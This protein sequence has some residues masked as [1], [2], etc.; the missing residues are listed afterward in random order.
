M[1]RPTVGCPECGKK[2]RKGDEGHHLA[3]ECEKRLVSCRFC[4]IV[5]PGEIAREHEE[6]C[7]AKT[8]VCKSCGSYVVVRD[9]VYHKKSCEED[10]LALPCEFCERVVPANELA[11]HQRKCL[12]HE[13][14][15]ENYI[16]K[17]D[18]A[19]TFRPSATKTEE[20]ESW[21]NNFIKR[22]MEKMKE[23]KEGNEA[24]ARK[25]RTGKKCPKSHRES[26]SI[27]A[28][29][30]EI[31]GELCPSD[32]LMD[33][34]IECQQERENAR[35][36]NPKTAQH[37]SSGERECHF[38]K[39]DFP[40]KADVRYI[41]VQMGYSPTIE[42]T[43]DDESFEGD[44]GLHFFPRGERNW[45][46]FLSSNQDSLTTRGDAG[47]C[48]VKYIEYQRSYSPAMEFEE[49]NLSEIFAHDIPPFRQARDPSSLFERSNPSRFNQAESRF[50][51][52]RN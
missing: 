27:V 30:C 46:D 10:N 13:K 24:T 33:H 9:F 4:A 7:G 41:E 21:E 37:A 32:K 17:G 40:Q 22:G 36:N 8:G 47:A 38:S 23:V 2:I 28:L 51:H 6:Y 1:F 5:L 3:Y 11:L 35:Q 26:I 15:D 20:K 49:E 39:H 42:F 52:G 50:G 16:L 34:Q 48:G 29:P 43:D 19:E 12:D 25:D 44:I 31:C 18:I 45:N 14:V